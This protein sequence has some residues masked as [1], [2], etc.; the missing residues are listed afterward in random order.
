L[1]VKKFLF[2]L[3][4]KVFFG[5]LLV[6]GTAAMAVVWA[7]SLCF[8]PWRSE[9]TLVFLG[10]MVLYL[11]LQVAFFKPILSHVMAHELTHALAAVLMGGKVTAIHATTTGGST[12]VNKSHI[13]I[14]LAPYIFPFYTA[15]TV[16]LY[17][18][19]AQPFKIYLL[20][21]I[22]FTYAFHIALTIYSLSHP[23]TDLKDGGVVFSLIF[24][25]AG[26]MIVVMLL[27]ALV[28]PQVLPLSKA[29]TDTIQWAWQLVLS[30]FQLVKPHLS[31]PEAHV[32]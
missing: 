26:N 18:I 11:V 24:I 29:V 30:L 10:G 5:V 14:S 7:K 9:I 16:G 27:T 28:W 15:V 8:I 21:L 31:R 25:L 6:W 22:G 17:A 2:G 1:A 13:F 32:P 4:L 19:A 23:Q 3:I 12:V 20:G